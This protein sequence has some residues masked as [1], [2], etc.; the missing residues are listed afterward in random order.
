M[1]TTYQQQANDFLAKTNTKIDI[2]YLKYDY[3]FYGD[4]D[5]RDIYKVTIKRGNRQFVLNFG[6]SL[7]RSGIQFRYGLMRTVEANHIVRKMVENKSNSLMNYLKNNSN[8]PFDINKTALKF[9]ELPNNYDILACLTK[10]EVGTF[11]DFCDNYGYNKDSITA[12]KTY[13][14]VVKEWENVCRIWSDNEIELLQEIQ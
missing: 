11:D 10:N 2:K 4:K 5:R 6:Q 1:E 3:H 14:A 12:K 7:A 8:I 9:Y 13:K